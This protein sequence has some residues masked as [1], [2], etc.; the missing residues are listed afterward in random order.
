[1]QEN[2]I[3]PGR[4]AGRGMLAIMWVMILA[5]LAFAFA[6]WEDKQ[7]NPNASIEGAVDGG[8]RTVVLKQNDWGHYVANGRINGSTVTFLLDTGATSVAIP[9]SLARKLKLKPGPRYWVST[10]NGNIEVRGTRIDRLELG[11][12]VF[13]NVPAAINPG[14]DDGE[15]LLGMSALKQVDF[16]QSGKQLTITQYLSP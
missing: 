11:P 6:K 2:E 10:A 5:A 15:I 16:Y 1:M 3:P 9:E 14:M 4:K 8:K 13:H 7:Y 12:I